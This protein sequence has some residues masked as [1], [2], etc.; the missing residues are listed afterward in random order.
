MTVARRSASAVSSG[1]L[2]IVAGGETSPG[3]LPVSSTDVV[4]V[5]NGHSWMMAQPLPVAWWGINLVLVN[6]EL[7]L[8]GAMALGREVFRATVQSLVDSTENDSQSQVWTTLPPAP[9]L[10]GS[11]AGY[12]NKILAFEEGLSRTAICAYF[13][14]TQSWVHVEDAPNY[15]Y[16]SCTLTLPTGD[17][18]V[19][20][21]DEAWIGQLEGME[22]DL[23]CMSTVE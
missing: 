13:P 8:S 12:N 4:E 1:N 18:M 22:C 15:I 10:I 6:C 7:Y 17:L 20:T 23:L 3:S 19:V 14:H 9:H 21:H 11:I 16:Y 2:I 5:F